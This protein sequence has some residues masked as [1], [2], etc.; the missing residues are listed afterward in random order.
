L[1]S[2]RPLALAL[3]AAASA[4]C[5]SSVRAGYPPLV[6]A[7]HTTADCQ[8]VGP[9]FQCL[10]GG[11]CGILSCICNDDCPTGL[12]CYP[13]T[14]SVGECIVTANGSPCDAG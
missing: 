1:K 12:A 10:D 5:S 11:A 8:S 2:L 6:T 9:E 13:T 3:V 14:V 7:C 4:A